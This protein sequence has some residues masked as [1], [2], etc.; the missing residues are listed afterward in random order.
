MFDTAEYTVF[1]FLLFGLKDTGIYLTA[2]RRRFLFPI[3]IAEYGDVL[4]A[5]RHLP[6]ISSVINCYISMNFSWVVKVFAGK[7]TIV[8]H[9]DVFGGK[10][11]I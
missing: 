2:V 11:S 4:R 7:R 10:R 9:T 5:T 3:W 1:G 6:F 8:P